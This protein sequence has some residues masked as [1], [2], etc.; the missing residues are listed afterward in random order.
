MSALDTFASFEEF[1]S[2]IQTLRQQRRATKVFRRGKATRRSPTKSKKARI[3]QKTSG[4]CH[5]C[6]GPIDGQW[7][8]D[9]VLAH[10]LGGEHDPDNYL[11]AHSICNKYRWF[12]EAEEIQWILKLG[13]WLRTE[14]EKETPL[15]RRAAEEFCEHDRARAG[16]RKTSGSKSGAAHG[17]RR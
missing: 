13:V 10:A 12:Y 17:R 4:R 9:H 2:R 8:V 15:G 6:G 11:P 7:Q 5:I 14:I 1:V 3:F 16:R